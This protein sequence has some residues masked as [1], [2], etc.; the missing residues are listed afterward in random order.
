MAKPDGPLPLGYYL[1]PPPPRRLWGTILGVISAAAGSAAWLLRVYDDPAHAPAWRAYLLL[2]LVV[3]GVGAGIVSAKRAPVAG[4]I[5][6]LISLFAALG[7]CG[8]AA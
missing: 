2:A 6:L 3:I 5:G 8:L 4:V 7:V 1:D